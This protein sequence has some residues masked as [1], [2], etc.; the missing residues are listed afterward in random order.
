MI[1]YPSRSKRK[2]SCSDTAAAEER[3][4]PENWRPP[5]ARFAAGLGPL[6]AA[7][8]A[9]TARMIDDDGPA[10]VKAEAPLATENSMAASRRRW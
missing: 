10:E 1:A 3:L 4:S 6:A 5:R 2:R 8:E 7:W 9:R